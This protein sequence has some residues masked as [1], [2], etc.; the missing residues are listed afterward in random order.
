[1]GKKEEDEQ[2]LTVVA[3]E[4]NAAHL[5]GEHLLHVRPEVGVHGGALGTLVLYRG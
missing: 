4:D 5:V 1:M 3:G 2:A